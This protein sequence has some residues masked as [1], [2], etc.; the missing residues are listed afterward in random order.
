MKTAVVHDYFTQMGGAER[1]AQQLYRIAPNASLF[2][3]VGFPECL[4][5]GLKEVKL[6]TTWMQ[7]LPGIRKSYRAYFLFYPLAIGSLDLSDFDLVLSSSSAYAK[8]VRNH[9]DSLHV[10]YCHTP[11]RWVWNY[12]NYA[13]R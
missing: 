10:C 6:N 3:T 1:V 13:A 8:G 11:M 2:A 4:P 12:N 5:P 9:P 7:N